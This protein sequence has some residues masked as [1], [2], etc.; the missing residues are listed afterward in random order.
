MTN[1]EG[2]SSERHLSRLAEK[3]NKS[4]AILAKYVC[5]PFVPRFVGA[6]QCEGAALQASETVF[7]GSRAD[8][9][10]RSK[11]A[12]ANL[13]GKPKPAGLELASE[14]AERGNYPEAKPN[15]EKAERQTSLQ[16][17]WSLYGPPTNQDDIRTIHSMA[18]RRRFADCVSR[19]ERKERHT[20]NRDLSSLRYDRGDACSSLQRRGRATS[21]DPF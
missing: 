11:G 4:D 13:Q 3:T 8:S 10:Y 7:G 1:T 18:I 12:A 14:A 6:T 19:A 9:L 16:E 2:K 21:D 17:E 20:S 15:E 5:L